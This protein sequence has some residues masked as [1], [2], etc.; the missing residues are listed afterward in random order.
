LAQYDS[1]GNRNWLEQPAPIEGVNYE[2][3]GVSA[4][5]RGN[6]FQLFG[7][8]SGSASL[9]DYDPTGALKWSVALPSGEA[10]YSVKADGQGF[11]YM[12]S[13]AGNVVYVRKFDEN[14]NVVWMRTLDSGSPYENSS[15]VSLDHLGNIYVVGYTYGSLI[16]PNAGLADGF[17]AKYNE[18][19]DLLWTRQFGT[20][21]YDFAFSVAADTLGN[22]FVSGGVYASQDAWNAG[23]QDIFIDKF[24]AAGNQI[25]TR[26]L[27]TTANDVGGSSWL[28]NLG[29]VYFAGYTSGALG[30]PNLGGSDAVVGK[31]DGGGSLLWIKQFGTSG[32]DT[33]NLFGNGQGD[34]FGV[35]RTSGSWGG[36]N[37]GGLDAVLLKFSPP[38]AA[39]S[40]SMLA[41]L[42]TT[43][44]AALVSNSLASSTTV[45]AGTDATAKKFTLS[46]AFTASAGMT[47]A[48]DLLLANVSAPK[49]RDVTVD[50]AFE[51][52]S[53]EDPSAGNA[54]LDDELLLALASI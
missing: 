46:G 40:A 54:S 3:V 43:T 23:N 37:A 33:S 35:G 7:V 22:V 8:N 47:S 45:M 41:S 39:M 48:T 14:G 19:G 12:S 24:D 52:M 1:A 28:D 38:A 49:K 30:G 9:N 53:L 18:G 15:G 20:P 4:D 10:I 13:Y 42:S 26:Q 34:F 51:G 31:Y 44:T 36:P 21:G 6:V 5:D 29:D 17:I 2:G 50:A 16:G 25:W 32:D 27:G 11:A